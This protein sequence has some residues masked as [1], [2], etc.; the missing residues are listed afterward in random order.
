MCLAKGL[1]VQK[2]RFAACS[3]RTRLVIAWLKSA[4]DVNKITSASSGSMTQTGPDQHRAPKHSWAGRGW[5]RHISWKNWER[6]FFGNELKWNLIKRILSVMSNLTGLIYWSPWICTFTN[7]S[8]MLIPLRGETWC[9]PQLAGKICAYVGIWSWPKW[10]GK[11]KSHVGQWNSTLC[12]FCRE[13][14]RI[15]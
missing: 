2:G 3:Q 1:N 11:K 9:S 5:Q 4:P 8:Y 12:Y 15:N 13:E 10:A 14:R 6:V 7:D